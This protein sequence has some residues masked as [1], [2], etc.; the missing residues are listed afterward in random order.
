MQIYKWNRN[1]SRLHIP[2]DYKWT[3]QVL[4]RTIVVVHLQALFRDIKGIVLL[5][6]SF[7]NFNLHVSTTVFTTKNFNFRKLASYYFWQ[8]ENAHLSAYMSA[9][10]TVTNQLWER[11]NSNYTFCKPRKICWN[12]DHVTTKSIER[13]R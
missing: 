3:A 1:E 4:D 2:W 6:S 10:K 11:E 13:G 8:A 7:S 5:N 9:N 12:V